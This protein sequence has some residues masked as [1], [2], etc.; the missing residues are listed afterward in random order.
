[1]NNHEVESILCQ[2]KCDCCG[3]VTTYDEEDIKKIDIDNDIFICPR[4]KHREY[5]ANV[6]AIVGA[7]FVKNEN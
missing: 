6:H 7:K 2:V 4:C 5:F 1:M 3:S